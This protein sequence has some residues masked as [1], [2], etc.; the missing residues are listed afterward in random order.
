MAQPA[1]HH[2]K[3]G[4][5]Y[6]P[7]VQK[8]VSDHCFLFSY[9]YLFEVKAFQGLLLILSIEFRKHGLIVRLFFQ[10]KSDPLIQSLNI[11]LQPPRPMPGPQKGHG[12]NRPHCHASKDK[13]ETDVSQKLK[14]V[15]AEEMPNERLR[16]RHQT[17]SHCRRAYLAFE[18][19]ILGTVLRFEHLDEYGRTARECSQALI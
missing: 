3:A 4:K 16:F 17:L 10:R 8:M 6:L 14:M 7:A 19:Q 12:K 11:L 15:A 9:R 18:I 2:D 13:H 1:R 5:L